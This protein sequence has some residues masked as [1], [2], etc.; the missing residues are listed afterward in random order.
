M[1]VYCNLLFGLQEPNLQWHIVF[2]HIGFCDL[3]GRSVLAKRRNIV[4]DMSG[5]VQVPIVIKDIHGQHNNRS[6]ADGLFWFDGIPRYNWS[7]VVQNA[8]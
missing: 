2:L 3:C 7:D 5:G 4:R 8:K 1:Y 6:R